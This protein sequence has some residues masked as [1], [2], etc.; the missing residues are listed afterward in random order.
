MTV[1]FFSRSVEAVLHFTWQ[2][3]QSAA[4]SD[5]QSCRYVSVILSWIII[6]RSAWL[7]CLVTLT[8]SNEVNAIAT[9]TQLCTV[10]L[11]RQLVGE[12]GKDIR[13]LDCRQ[14]A[15]A[16]SMHH[17]PAGAVSINTGCVALLALLTMWYSNKRCCWQVWWCM[18]Q[19]WRTCSV[20]SRW[21]R[22]HVVLVPTSSRLRMLRTSRSFLPTCWKLRFHIS[23]SESQHCK[24]KWRLHLLITPTGLLCS[25]WHW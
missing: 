8:I 7:W 12:A 21:T 19:Y 2:L 17:C 10:T 6:I 14:I 13:F 5:S 3:H 20:W 16:C 1:V 22:W 15:T 11:Y 24:Y 25:S 18:P 23:T 9:A 4:G